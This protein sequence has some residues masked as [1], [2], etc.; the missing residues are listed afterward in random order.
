[1][2]RCFI[3]HEE[4]LHHPPLC[5]VVCDTIVAWG[6]D[7]RREREGERSAK[8]TSHTI[9]RSM[10]LGGKFWHFFNLKKND[11]NTYIR[12]EK[13]IDLNLSDFKI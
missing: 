7:G 3:I 11:F 2:K 4:M 13:K 9:T 10:F 1:M 8:L 5:H 12:A 6:F